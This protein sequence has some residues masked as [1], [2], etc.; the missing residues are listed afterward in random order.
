MTTRQILTEV[1]FYV[2]VTA[3][4]GTIIAAVLYHG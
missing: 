1:I 2:I 4:V 3:V